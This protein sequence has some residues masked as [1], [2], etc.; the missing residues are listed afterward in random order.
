MI[1]RPPRSTLSSSSA[2]SDVYKRQ[3]QECRDIISVVRQKLLERGENGFRGLTRTLRILDDNGNK[4]LD[5]RE[6]KNGMQT[7]G[8]HMTDYEVN[9]LMQYFDRNGDGNIS[10]GEFVTGLRPKM[11]D[12]R[13]ALVKLAFLRLDKN[14][15]GVVTMGELRGLY[16]AERNPAVLRGEKTVD[17]VLKE[18]SA[19]WNAN[20]DQ[21]ITEN[22]FLDYYKDLSATIDNDSYFELMV[23]NAWHIS[24]GEGQAANTANLRL[25]VTHM[26]G[27][28]TIETLDD[29]LGVDS[30]S[31]DAL[32]N[33]LRKQGV[34]DI[35]KVETATH[36]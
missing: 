26:D 1:R 22:E 9:T 20:G 30:S 8:I 4:M 18:F 12:A 14:P 32:V 16:R 3:A 2:A 11:S 24:G 27:T 33:A 15:D 31:D 7:Y 6:L 34:T 21:V 13:T 29:D 28:S 17:E 19:A 36:C 10:V 5:K 35:L 25:L 23:R